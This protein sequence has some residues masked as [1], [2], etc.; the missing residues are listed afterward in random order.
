[1]P[2]ETFIMLLLYVWIVRY[3]I[4]AA[5]GIHLMYTKKI[6]HPSTWDWQIQLIVGLPFWIGYYIGVTIKEIVRWRC[7]KKE[8]GK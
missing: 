7:R 3:I 1:M 5:Y 6:S 2:W 8:F 4:G